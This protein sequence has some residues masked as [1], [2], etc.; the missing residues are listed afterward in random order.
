[1]SQEEYTI[2]MEL[3]EKSIHDHPTIKKIRNKRHR[4]RTIKAFKRMGVQTFRVPCVVQN[5]SEF[6]EKSIPWSIGDEAWQSEDRN[7]LVATQSI[8][9]VEELVKNRFRPSSIDVT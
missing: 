2:T 9:D 8:D 3:A 6:K 5:P 1:M 4:K 7:F